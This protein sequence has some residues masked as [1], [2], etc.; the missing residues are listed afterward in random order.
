MAAVDV[1]G[2]SPHNGYTEQRQRDHSPRGRRDV[3]QNRCVVVRHLRVATEPY[4]LFVDS[5]VATTGETWS[6]THSEF[7]TSKTLCG[8]AFIRF[9]V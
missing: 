5:L 2:K 3:G 9:C 8:R 4:V 6:T 1:R 7:L